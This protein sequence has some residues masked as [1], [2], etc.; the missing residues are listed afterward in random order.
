MQKLD[1]MPLLLSAIFEAILLST[2][3]I[4]RRLYGCNGVKGALKGEGHRGC[5]CVA[6]PGWHWSSVRGQAGPAVSRTQRII[7]HPI[8]ARRSK[9]LSVVHKLR[10]GLHPGPMERFW[11][12]NKC[13]SDAF[14][15]P[16]IDR[17]KQR[18]G[19]S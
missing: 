14:M 12:Q 5:V 15:I 17:L 3:I 6:D 11:N 9:E 19:D 18:E 2:K 4:A 7:T 13:P 16:F 8:R 1:T 10:A